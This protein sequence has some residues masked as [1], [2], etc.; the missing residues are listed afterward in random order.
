MSS[1]KKTPGFPQKKNPRSTGQL[2]IKMLP[3]RSRVRGDV[4]SSSKIKASPK[5][6]INAPAIIAASASYA[7][8][9]SKIVLGQL[10][11]MELFTK[12]IVPAVKAVEVKEFQELSDKFKQDVIV[13]DLSGTAKVTVWEDHVVSLQQ[14]RSCMLKNFVVRTFQ[15]TKYLSREA[16]SEIIQIEDIGTVHSL[17]VS[18]SIDGVKEVVLMGVMVVEVAVLETYKTC[19]KCHSR[20]KPMEMPLGC[21]SRFECQMIHLCQDLTLAKLVVMHGSSP[22]DQK[23]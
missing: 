8:I 10:P 18:N 11:D 1:N 6:E 12:V 23:K 9:V 16:N 4:K 14:G 19:F 5:K 15:S 20:V 17:Q 3:L 21:C 13:S 22:D 2:Q 7:P